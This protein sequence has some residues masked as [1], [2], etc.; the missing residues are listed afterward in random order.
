MTLR[1]PPLPLRLLVGLGCLAVAAIALPAP[2]RADGESRRN[3]AASSVLRI[4]GSS[5]VFPILQTAIEAYRAAGNS[6]AIDLR[7]SGS[8][9]GFRRFCQG[10]LEIANA[11][12]PINNRELKSCEAKGVVFLELPI[13]FDAISVVVHPSNSWAKQISLQQLRTL[14]NRQ[15]QGRINRWNQVNPSWPN[16]PIKLCGPGADSG[17]FD[18]FN[19]AVSGSPENSRRDYTASEDDTVIARCV[20][21]DPSALGYFGF[22]HYQTNRNNLRA[23]PISSLSGAVAPSR[24][25]VQSGK[26]PLARPLFLYIND[27]A[28]TQRS[29]VQRFTS[30]TVRNG[31]RLVE[32]AGEIPLPASTYNLVESKLY[33]RVTG[34]SF[35]GD[36]PVGLT[37]GDVLRRSFDQNKLPQ[38]R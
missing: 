13:A 25:S 23:L 20:A 34:S 36:L 14:W 2:S 9:D 19:K 17:T 29:E 15:A 21:K 4:G 18:F 27:K 35:A 37:I 24:S 8:T 7:E 31:L 1:T 6:G 12:R 38:F 33:R 3:A 16:R 22:S 26:Y 5:T 28:L 10:Q 11:S 30:F 32:K